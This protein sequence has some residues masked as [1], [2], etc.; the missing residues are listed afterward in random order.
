MSNEHNRNIR[1]RQEM[2][3]Q[4]NA[5]PINN[6]RDLNNHMKS[7]PPSMRPG[8]VGAINDVIWPFWFTGTAPE[9]APNTSATSFTTITQEAAFVMMAY[10]KAVYLRSGAPGSYVYTFV[11]SLDE[12]AA[13]QADGLSFTIKDSGSTRTF[14]NKPLEIDQVGG[15]EFP[16]VLPTPIMFLP[17]SNIEIAY[18]NNHAANT[19]VPFITFFGYRVRVDEAQKLLS[20]VTG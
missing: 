14:H 4:Q 1:M 8:N 17:N 19:Y 6:A 18:Q 7:L 20:T 16:S 2:M 9:M 10:T 3:R 15:G 13:G 11:D 12:S 5:R